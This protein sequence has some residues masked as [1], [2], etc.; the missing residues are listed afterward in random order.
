M[1]KIRLRRIGKKG[2]PTYRVVVTDSR[3]PR[4]GRF[5]E[6][7]GNYDP[8]PDPSVIEIDGARA[9][10][11]IGKGAQPSSAVSRLLEVSGFLERQP[12]AVVNRR[13]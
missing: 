7:I 3:S 11:W 9:L 13:S 2:A 6:N 12:K 8:G 5:I 10:D 4:D 1:V